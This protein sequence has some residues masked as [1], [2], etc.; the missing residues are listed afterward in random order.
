V[1]API[2]ILETEKTL[3]SGRIYKKPKKTKKKPKKTKKNQ[4]KHKKPTGL[5]FLKKP[6]FFQP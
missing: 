3:S 2:S 1:D 6:G 4:K 5:D